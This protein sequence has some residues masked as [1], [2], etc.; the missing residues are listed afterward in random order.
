MHGDVHFESTEEL[1]EFL[2]EFT[3]STATFV[4]RKA[5]PNT[6]ISGGAW[7]LTFTGGH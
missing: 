6:G 3:G 5:A 2:R 4:V 1:A 7:V